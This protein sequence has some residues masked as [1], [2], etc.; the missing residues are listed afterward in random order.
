MIVPASTS[1]F[2]AEV[3]RIMRSFAFDPPRSA[4][5]G[6]AC[7]SEEAKDFSV[8]NNSDTSDLQVPSVAVNFKFSAGLPPPGMV[9]E[10]EAI[11][12][13]GDN[14]KRVFMHS[15]TAFDVLDTLLEEAKKYAGADKLGVRCRIGLDGTRGNGSSARCTKAVLGAL[16]GLPG[17]ANTGG[18]GGDSDHYDLK[19]PGN[20]RGR[21]YQ[22]KV[23]M[24]VT[25]ADD[26]SRHQ[27][28]DIVACGG[29]P[30]GHGHIQVYTGKGC[31]STWVS[32]FRQK[33]ILISAAYNNCALHRA[34]ME[35][36]AIIRKRCSMSYDSEIWRVEVV[37]SPEE[38]ASGLQTNSCTFSSGRVGVCRDVRRCAQDGG[39]TEQCKYNGI[40]SPL[41]DDLL[42]RA[43]T[44]TLAYVSFVSWRG[45]DQ[46]L[47]GCINS[48]SA[49]TGK[50]II[51][52]MIVHA[53]LVHTLLIPV[54]LFHPVLWTVRLL[55]PWTKYMM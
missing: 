14:N 31:G 18:M 2:F 43:L 4:V 6:Y 16:T 22:T 50:C 32:D 17:F 5:E 51:S 30:S 29:G 54:R 55:L 3:R 21:G 19:N 37:A 38:L 9:E 46:M 44:H 12:T 53:D 35:T 26:L 42:S 52:L 47:F 28:G 48:C 13:K 27:P 39:F 11:R 1:P 10:I 15:R 45:I 7:H 33:G 41:V 34:T 36:A 25:Y 40:R 20:F 24:P 23:A 8:S 49:K